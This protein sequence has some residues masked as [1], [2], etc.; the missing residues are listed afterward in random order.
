M[1]CCR[2]CQKATEPE[3]RKDPRRLYGLTTKPNANVTSAIRWVNGCVVML[4]M[5]L[6]WRVRHAGP[7]GISRQTQCLCV[8]WL[9]TCDHLIPVGEVPSQPCLY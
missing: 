7:T 9:Y 2:C 5:A 4:A 3:I 8:L 6:A 1:C